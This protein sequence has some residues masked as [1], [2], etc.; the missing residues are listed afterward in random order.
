[1]ALSSEGQ[2]EVTFYKLT[3]EMPQD[4]DAGS[5]GRVANAC[6]ARQALVMSAGAIQLC[7]LLEDEQ[8]LP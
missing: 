5:R 7:R 4:P 8:C 6:V 2:A 3:L 1:M